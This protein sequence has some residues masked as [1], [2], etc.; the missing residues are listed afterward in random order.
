MAMPLPDLSEVTLAI[1]SFRNDAAILALL[2]SVKQSGARFAGVLVVDSLGTGEILKAIASRG[3]EDVDYVSADENLGSAGNLARRLEL[4]AH[5]RAKY[6]Y[7]VNH[8]GAVDPLTVG[9]LLEVARA[10]SS[11]AAAYPLRRMTNRSGFFDV[12]G[13]FPVPLTAMRVQRAPREV[14]DVYW[15]SSNGALYSLDVVRRGLTP[16][17]DLWMCWEDLGY[18]WLLRRNGYRQVVVGTAVADDGYEYVRRGVRGAGAWVI[19]K[20]AWY[21][22]YSARNFLLVAQRTG[23]PLHVRAAVLGRV[24][25]EYVLTPLFRDHKL[26]RLRYVSAGIA[27]A[28]RGRT[29]KWRLP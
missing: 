25:F 3:W 19:R 5:S 6:V 2:D 17:S 7:A 24:L 9:K 20:P 12:T 4:A 18:G 14:F 26:N 29:G 13:R 15:S 27:D 1:S 11:I 10:D 8:D 23:Q 16:W 22:Y 28:A 21:S